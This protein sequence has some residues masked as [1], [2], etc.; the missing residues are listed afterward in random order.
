MASFGFSSSGS[1]S[2]SGSAPKPGYIPGT[3]PG[4]QGATST[5]APPSLG[6]SPSSPTP[7]G[8]T[9][10]DFSNI[11]K[12][13]P[14]LDPGKIAAD[15]QALLKQ[16]MPGPITAPTIPNR[17]V[18]I[19]GGTYEGLTKG[20]YES[21]FAPVQRELQRQQGLA[22]TALQG[23]LAGAGLAESGAGVAQVSQQDREFQQR[24]EDASRDI[25]AAATAAGYNAQIA[26][27]TTNA[28]L[29]QERNLAQ[30]GFQYAAQAEN[31]R[32]ILQGNTMAAQ[33]YLAA[34]GINVDQ[35]AKYR[36]SFLSYLGMKEQSR[37][38]GDTTR[39]TA[40]T[41]VFNGALQAASLN[42]TNDTNKARLALDAKTADQNFYMALHNVGDVAV[43]GLRPSE[44][45]G[46]SS[47]RL[48]GTSP[49][50][51]D[52]FRGIGF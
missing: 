40:A 1:G 41:T 51:S 25:S 23:N 46:L 13:P 14:G 12:P 30:A 6:F 27:E 18:N 43:T 2:G 16:R 4:S 45:Y 37:L 31:A 42:F 38:A 29:A 17:Q 50:R 19:P 20:I 26:I 28:Q 21:Q 36:D 33:G 15:I 52:M 3:I 39:L 11:F 24:T 47:P 22:D 10:Q 7:I 35:A 49:A 34:L 5:Y 48:A 9:Y 8:S 32:N 44:S